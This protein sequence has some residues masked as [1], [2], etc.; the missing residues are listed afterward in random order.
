MRDRNLASYC[1]NNGVK[2]GYVEK[3]RFEQNLREVRELAQWICG[4]R[5]FEN[6]ETPR[7]K[8]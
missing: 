1:T 6:K 5:A 8:P 2:V 3:M 7:V 4:E